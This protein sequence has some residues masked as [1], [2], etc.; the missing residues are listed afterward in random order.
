MNYVLQRTDQGGGYVAK[1]G[2]RSSYTH[3]IAKARKF[4][5]FRE[6]DEARCPGNER[7]VHVNEVL[8]LG[9]P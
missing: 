3:S 4:A 7:V 5:T 1:P 2:Q 9:R 6:A 8:G